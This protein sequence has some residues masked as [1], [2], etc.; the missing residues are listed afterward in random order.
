[1]A[2][3]ETT[4]TNGSHL[5]GGDTRIPVIPDEH[6]N[7][8]KP[9]Q[10]YQHIL[11]IFLYIHDPWKPSHNHFRCFVYIKLEHV[12]LCKCFF[13]IHFNNFR[14]IFV[15]PWSWYVV[16]YTSCMCAYVR[17][18]LTCA[19]MTRTCT[20]MASDTSWSAAYGEEIVRESALF[21]CSACNSDTVSA[22]VRVK[23]GISCV[24]VAEKLERDCGYDRSKHNY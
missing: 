9:E 13:E 7:N 16:F 10:R 24:K 17:M 12:L 11:F 6:A 15:S 18:S 1:M 22:M 5:N 2:A 21:P 4:H 3:P 20:W 14:K 8:V 23:S 19:G